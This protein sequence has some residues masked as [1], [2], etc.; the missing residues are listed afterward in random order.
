[1]AKKQ[2]ARKSKVAKKK[3]VAKRGGSKSATPSKARNAKVSERERK[4]QRNQYLL[5]MDTA[6][7]ESQKKNRVN[8]NRRTKG[9]K[10]NPR[11]YRL[12][13]L[14]PLDSGGN[15]NYAIENPIEYRSK[16]YDVYISK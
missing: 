9:T 15:V 3:A 8:L 13:D 2:P 4:R 6:Y 5:E 16:N 10:K 7:Y 14:E 12:E 1:M 11:G